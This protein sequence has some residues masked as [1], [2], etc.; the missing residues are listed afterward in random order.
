MD[1]SRELNRR[2]SSSLRPSSSRPSSWAQRSPNPRRP[3]PRLRQAVRDA[4]RLLG[5]AIAGEHGSYWL[6]RAQVDV[7]L[8]ELVRLL[9]TVKTCQRET[10]RALME[11]ALRLFHGEPLAGADYAWS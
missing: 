7:D 5:T 8:D 1:A 4:R 3:R 9:A 6:D 11:S 10:A 2:R